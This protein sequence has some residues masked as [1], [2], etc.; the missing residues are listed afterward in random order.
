[1]LKA[2][3]NSAERILWIKK[4]PLPYFKIETIIIPCK[5]KIKK[6]IKYE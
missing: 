3:L 2:I 5:I 6:K 1:M 4:S